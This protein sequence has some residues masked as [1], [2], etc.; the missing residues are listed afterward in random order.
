MEPLHVRI[1]QDGQGRNGHAGQEI[2][3]DENSGLVK[4]CGMAHPGWAPSKIG[5][6]MSKY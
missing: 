5:Y 6:R 4:K 3:N 2:T 1:D